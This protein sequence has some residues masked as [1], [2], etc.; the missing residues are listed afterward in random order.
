[1]N[2][3]EI[4]FTAY[5]VTDILRAREFYE[6]L[7]GLSPGEID[8]EVEGMPGKFWIEYDVAGATFAISNTWEPSK[9][10]G[11]PSIAFEVDD[12]DASVAQLKEA[13]VTFLAERIDSP[14]CCFALILDPDGNGITIHKRNDS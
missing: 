12:F 7:L 6:N 13:G 5:P 1:M 14:V 2:I 9:D 8:H 10:G 11:G 3:R 4:A